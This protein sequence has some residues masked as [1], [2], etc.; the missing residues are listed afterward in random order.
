METKSEIWDVV[1]CTHVGALR[2]AERLAR[3]L[4][5]AGLS[6]WYYGWQLKLGEPIKTHEYDAICRSR[7]GLTLCDKR[8]GCVNLGVMMQQKQRR[9][10]SSF[11]V[12]HIP[13]PRPGYQTPAFAQE[14]PCFDLRN[15]WN[16]DGIIAVARQ[17]QNRSK[18]FDEAHAPPSLF[19]CHAAE[20]GQI[21]EEIYYRLTDAG[22][23]PWFDQ[24][25]LLAGDHWE[26]EIK[27]AIRKSDFFVLFLSKASVAKRGFIQKEVRAAIDEY[28]HRPHGLAYIVPVLLDEC[29]VPNIPLDQGT[30]LSHMK[31]SVKLQVAEYF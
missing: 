19:L 29:A 2:Y 16:E 11:F 15:S 7:V 13:H 28:Q 10:S 9:P 25:K 8:G 4:A 26:R 31:N 1:V 3:H 12:V 5:E 27:Q 6:V 22:L 20:D 24:D 18:S 14:F 17:L 30:V 23:N 21:V